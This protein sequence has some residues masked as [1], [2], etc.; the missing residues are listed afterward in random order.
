MCT[1]RNSRT[2]HGEDSLANAFKLLHGRYASYWNAAHAK[3]GHTW[4]GRFY[5]CPLD[6][7]HLCEALRYTELNPVRASM[8][9]AAESWKWSSAAVPSEEE[10]HRH[11]VKACDPRDTRQACS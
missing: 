1:D 9:E 8:V 3:S 5:S 11:L 2:V 4:Q 7:A 10:L 6:E